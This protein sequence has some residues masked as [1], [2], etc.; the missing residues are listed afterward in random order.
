MNSRNQRH[1]VASD[2]NE[3][4]NSVPMMTEWLHGQST[5]SLDKL[6]SLIQVELQERDITNQE[7]SDSDDSGLGEC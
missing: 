2:W 6:E 1:F 3:F 5:E 7:L 4:D